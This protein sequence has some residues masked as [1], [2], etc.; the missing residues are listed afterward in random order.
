V[1][2]CLLPFLT[3]CSSNEL[4]DKTPE[5]KRADL[6]YAQGTSKLI[7]KQ[8]TEA[9]SNLIKADKLKP[10]DSK[11]KN[12]LAMAYYFKGQTKLAI[13]LL[14]ESIELNPQN[15][16][17]KVN[18]GSIYFQTNQYQLAKNTYKQILKDLVYKHQY[19]TH[20]NLALIAL[21]QDRAIEAQKHL[22]LSLK[23][24]NDYC[25]SLFQLGVIERE[26][27]NYIE[28][29]K[30]F[31]E[32]TKSTCTNDPRPH[33]EVASTYLKLGKR[34]LAEAK[35]LSVIRNFPSSPYADRS[36]N[37]LRRLGLKNEKINNLTKKLD[38][39]IL[40]LTKGKSKYIIET[41]DF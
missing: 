6:Y 18:L 22:Y 8:Y 1:I 40:D 12:N 4:V 17:A 33:Y 38:N 24:R 3:M 9:L 28:A 29:L 13:S 26:S 37:Q 11:V 15:S 27:G 32:S 21:K 31:Q 14:N 2:I 35:L 5:Q 10:N 7:K 36:R 23:D 39:D 20:Y 19:R 25:P 30:H 41:Q 34:Y 16:D